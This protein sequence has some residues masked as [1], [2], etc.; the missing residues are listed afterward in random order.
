MKKSILYILIFLLTANLP[1]SP[2]HSRLKHTIIIDT[3]CSVYDLRAVSILL[4]HPGITVKAIIVSNGQVKAGE[5]FARMNK[6]LK[7]SQAD[8]IPLFLGE[9]HD[10]KNKENKKD[11]NKTTV[12]NFMILPKELF[13][14]A[15]TELT[16]V[17]LGPLTNITR[18]KENNPLFRERVEEIIWYVD[19]V[20]PF[21]GFNYTSDKTSADQLLNSG[22]RFNAISNLDKA[23]PVFDSELISQCRRSGTVI[24]KALLCISAVT[25]SSE[26]KGNNLS[27]IA[28]EVA[29]FFLGNHEL[30]EITPRESSLNIRFNTVHNTPLLK[31]VI[32]DMIN[33]Q[34]RSGHFVALYGF[35]V[36]TELYVYDVRQILKPAIS[37]YGIEEWKAC[38]LTDEF[39]GHLGVFSIV[40]AKMGILARDFFGIGTD[41]LE[42]GSYAGSVEPFSCMNDGLQVS[43][44]A[45]LGQGTI[46]LINDTIARPQ[47]VFTYNNKSVLIK[48]KDEYLKEIKSVIARGVRN[49]GLQDEDYW[50]LIRQTSIKFWLEWNRNEIFDLIIL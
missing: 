35:P 23:T 30:F 42:I 44:G 28:E 34:Y 31:E 9:P 39:H 26:E 21:N 46:H 50:N 6:L 10:V 48:L 4:S 47:A 32:R 41:L 40:G 33:G 3:D 2:L 13:Q 11:N 37:K 12:K 7:E 17:C 25:L 36:N 1:A 18:E 20:N 49:Y 5:G 22:I 29:A 14:P 45:T 43:T 8:T 16:I 38:T 15:D 19:S 24:S 27:I